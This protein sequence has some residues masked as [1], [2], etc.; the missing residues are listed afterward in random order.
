MSTLFQNV[1]VL[2]GIVLLAVLGYFLYMQNS[3]TNAIGPGNREVSA[4]AAA[5]T[6]TFLRRLNEL[7]G[8]ELSSDIFFDP[9]FT[10]LIDFSTPVPGFQVGRSNPF[11]LDN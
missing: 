8:I 11:E 10:S 7:R 4:Q 3:G 5:E 9:R 6:E 2:F 1:I